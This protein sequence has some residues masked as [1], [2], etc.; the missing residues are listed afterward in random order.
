MEVNKLSIKSSARSAFCF[1][2][3]AFLARRASLADAS[4]RASSS[5]KACSSEEGV[6]VG[7]DDEE[8]EED[9]GGPDGLDERL[10]SW[11]SLLR[12]A[13]VKGA[14]RGGVG[15]KVPSRMRE[16]SVMLDVAR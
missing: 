5:F 3:A 1:A 4:L 10:R 14:E 11:E 9:T 12:F 13:E 15:D 7:T 16:E 6:C 2:S 8:E